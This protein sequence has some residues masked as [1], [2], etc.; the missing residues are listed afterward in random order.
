MV[1]ARD[2]WA[3]DVA[4]KLA[5]LGV[6]YH[7]V[8]PEEVK[9]WSAAQKAAKA[10]AKWIGMVTYAANNV[11]TFPF[12]DSEA[13]RWR[14]ASAQGARA[15]KR[16]DIDGRRRKGIRTEKP[17]IPSWADLFGQFLVF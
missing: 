13:S 1:E 9:R 8:A 3:N 6:E 7:R 10:R 2:L 15:N 5:K 11:P 12:R 16:R 17:I 14:A 4:D